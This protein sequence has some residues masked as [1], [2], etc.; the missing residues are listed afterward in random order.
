ME[1]A[2]AF[3]LDTLRQS[4]SSALKTIQ[5]RHCS[6]E[7]SF[8]LA[9]VLAFLP[10]RRHA[11]LATLIKPAISPAMAHFCLDQPKVNPD[12]ESDLE[13]V[14]KIL[15]ML[16]RNRKKPPVPEVRQLIF[17]F[18]DILLTLPMSSSQNTIAQCC[19]WLWHVGDPE[20]CR[21]IPQTVLYIL[22]RSLG[23]ETFLVG[24]RP[25]HGVGHKTVVRRVFAMRKAI[26]EIDLR[27]EN[28]DA[29]TMHTLLLQCATSST[30]L[31]VPEGRKFIASLLSLD[32]VR[33][34]IFDELICRLAAVKK[35]SAALFGN[36]FLHAWVMNR[37]DWL[38]E[39]FISVSEKAVRASCDPFASNLR[40]VMSSFHLNKR[41]TGVDLLLH[42]IYS[43][44]L[45]GNLLVANPFVRK[46]S[47]TI[48][49]DAFPIHDPGA[50]REEIEKTI[51]FQ[52]SKFLELLIDP[53]P[54]VRCAAI[55]GVCRILHLYW[56]LVPQLAGKK[57]VDL[58]TTKLA[59]DSSSAAVRIAVF[60]GLRTLLDNHLAHPLLVVVLPNLRPLV[61]DNVEKVRL[62][63][64][65]M[66]LKIKE[67]RLKTLRYFDVVPVDDLLLR[68][69][70]EPPAA[71]VKIMR[72]IVTSYF[73]LERASMSGD[74]LAKRQIKACLSMLQNCEGA[75]RY[76]YHNVNMY[77][78]PG[79]L[80]EFALR[81]S[82]VAFAAQPSASLRRQ[83][84]SRKGKRKKDAKRTRHGRTYC[85]DE[86]VAPADS[87]SCE[88]AEKGDDE[89][90][91]DELIC[92]EILLTTVADVLV[93]VGPSLEK[94]KNAKL[95]EYV[96]NI[97]SGGVLK[98]YLLLRGNSVRSRVACWRIASCISATKIKEITCLWREQMDDVVDWRRDSE[99]DAEEY[100]S[101]LSSMT[102]CA[103]RWNMLSTL[104]AVVSRWSECAGRGHRT[105]RVGVKVARKGRRTKNGRKGDV[106]VH[107]D[108]RGSEDNLLGERLGSL[109]ALQAFGSILIEDGGEVRC[110]LERA[111]AVMSDEDSEDD[112]IS[113][114]GRLVACIRKGSVGAF[115][116]VLEAMA[117]GCQK[118]SVKEYPL[119]L[120]TVVVALETSLTFAIRRERWDGVLQDVREIMEWL[121]G[122]DLWRNLVR[123]DQY[124]G[125]TLLSVC[126]GPI[127][128]AV[129]LQRFNKRDLENLETISEH[130][131]K[132]WNQYSLK[133][134]SRASS[135]LLRLA[136]QLDEQS[137]FCDS[138]SI[139][140]PNAYSASDLQNAGFS[141]ISNVLNILKEVQ[142]D[143]GKETGTPFKPTE[144]QN[145]INRGLVYMG[146]AQGRPAFSNL[147]GH[148]LIS[149]FEDIETAKTN[150]IASTVCNGVRELVTNPNWGDTSDA[151]QM[152]SFVWHAMRND[153][154]L[155]ARSNG[156]MISFA[157]NMLSSVQ[158]YYE[159]EDKLPSI[160]A[161]EFF[162]TVE[163]TID[164]T[165]SR[166]EEPEDVAGAIAEVRDR[167]A[168]LKNLQETDVAKD[169]S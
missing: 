113:S 75:A 155:T 32:D 8:D 26:H 143:E 162:R 97:F 106:V 82:S 140:A 22:M 24:G 86:N 144:L 120:K 33:D 69:P 28:P 56:E 148:L 89:K 142:A 53:A 30:Y 96:D 7:G 73:P 18:H 14:S 141:I 147:I 15:F 9:D 121:A 49:A 54:I 79:P 136:F 103:F 70:E 29:K 66:L 117:E 137:T 156:A 160:P 1:T 36:V 104:L 116:Y 87:N 145:F 152:F 119:L 83:N 59:F 91:S 40:T 146:K 90:D 131:A 71:A 72:L 85:N 127:A 11:E 93:S 64:L 57:M 10:D 102:I 151:T 111:L 58:I 45:F 130:M 154:A 169:G 110:E 61:D 138:C 62:S 125:Y 126:L 47:V 4:P 39:R 124:F 128:D 31:Q 101:L 38:V 13:V 78:P 34:A 98:P 123:V 20:R 55:E 163:S 80:C 88:G 139:R 153:S 41:M 46:N 168:L 165:F 158:T 150:F 81:L 50:M 12:Y 159:R 149:K 122:E 134:V 52:C 43:P 44:T 167:L 27:V 135:E 105:V 37:S 65:D 109:F 157:S 100:H 23:D 94:E 129:V 133:H 60:D 21:A 2:C 19:E 17:D 42:R 16:V 67:K 48:L 63:V 92:K 132:K 5:H 118:K 68:L 74:D 6:R 51:E 161:R 95:R 77:V 25:N 108:Q 112:T 166:G 99:A 3:L 107:E 84:D 35:S 76:F 115:D 164:G 114:P